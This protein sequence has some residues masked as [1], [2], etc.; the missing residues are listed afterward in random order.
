[1]GGV[2]TEILVWSDFNQETVERLCNC[3]DVDEK[4]HIFA[5]KLRVDSSDTKSAILLD[6][7]QGCLNFTREQ[8]FTAEGTSVILAVLNRVHKYA[9]KTSFENTIDSASFMR[10]LILT[11]SYSRPPF[12]IEVFTPTEAKAAL[13]FIIDTYFR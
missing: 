11:H 6:A 7:F 10:E 3:E 1:M 2:R 13:D 4:R 5:D 9:C 12:A 8:N